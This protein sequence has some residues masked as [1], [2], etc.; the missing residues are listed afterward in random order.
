MLADCSNVRDNVADGSS[1]FLLELYE[2]AGFS[3]A[4]LL[5]NE[6]LSGSSLKEVAITQHYIRQEEDGWRF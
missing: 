1:E 6:E 2:K 5:W 3:N 4:G